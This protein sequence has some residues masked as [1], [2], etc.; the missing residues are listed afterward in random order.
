MTKREAVV[1]QAYTGITMLVGDDFQIFT[2]YCEDLLGH[3]IFHMN[4]LIVKK[5]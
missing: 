2:K 5:I 4:T 3:P 1:I